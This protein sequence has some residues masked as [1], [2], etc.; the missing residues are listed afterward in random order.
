MSFRVPACRHLAWV[1]KTATLRA[2]R[3]WIPMVESAASLHQHA[4][5]AAAGVM[6]SHPQHR[7]PPFSRPSQRHQ[8]GRQQDVCA[9]FV[10]Q[11][12]LKH[13]VKKG[14]KG[15]KGQKASA[16]SSTADGEDVAE[17]L[18]DIAG[19]PESK[20][21]FDKV[22]QGLTRDFQGLRGGKTDP[23]MLD[24]VKVES[25]GSMTTLASVAQ[26]SM[27]GPQLIVLSVYDP[28]MTKAVEDAIRECGMGLN[29]NSEGQGQVHVPIPKPT[30]ESR[31]AVAKVA[32]KHAE[33]SKV[34]VRGIRHKILDQIKKKK[35]SFPEDDV[36][37]RIK[38]IDKCTKDAEAD[39][40]G[41]LEKKKVE[42]LTV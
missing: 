25:Y 6:A 3:K 10:G 20:A 36:H 24:N 42:I 34:V 13:G 5:A 33:K 30:K 38:E 28:G 32:A 4:A 7:H 8:H 40:A 35:D 17:S 12:R 11:I 19:I 27:K 18:D 1:R 39:I 23:G 21:R 41:M 26:A 9:S 31:E 22:L 15:G 29:P 14:K 2:P 37:M 16:P